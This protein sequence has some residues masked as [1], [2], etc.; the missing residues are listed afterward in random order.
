MKNLGII[1]GLSKVRMGDSDQ[2]LSGDKSYDISFNAKYMQ[3]LPADI[4]FNLVTNVCYRY[5][6]KATTSLCLR[7]DVIKKGDALDV[8]TIGEPITASNSGA[9]LQIVSM[10]ENAISQNKVRLLI[11]IQ[12]MGTGVAYL[13][14]EALDAAKCSETGTDMKEL[15]DKIRVT[16]GFIDGN[17][18]V[19]CGT[20]GGSNTGI[21]Q[22][23]SGQK[24]R[25]TCELDTSNLQETTFTKNP[26]VVVDYVYKDSVSQEMIVQNIA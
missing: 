22:L 17:P 12:N 2:V 19:S 20:F 1:R 3:D 4:P 6:T 8:C 11:E 13:A 24:S 18:S 10:V 7:R 23:I 14:P 9:P 16:V 21:V 5:Q 15:R 26:N 25:V